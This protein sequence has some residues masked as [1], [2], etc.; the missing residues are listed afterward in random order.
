MRF[1]AFL[2]LLAIVG[3]SSSTSTSAPVTTAVTT[4]A[5]SEADH[6]HDV[7]FRKT[8]HLGKHHAQLTAHIS[9][10]T[11]NELDLFLETTDEK[12]TPVALPL[13]KIVGTATRDGFLSPYELIFEPAPASERPKDEKPGTCSHFVAKAPWMKPDDTLVVTITAELSGRDRKAT[14]KNFEVKKF[15]HHTE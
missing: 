2:L 14:W 13:T 4:N 10:K 6:T 1:L 8:A 15:T 11:G 3:C 5:D 7:N 9:S 12:P